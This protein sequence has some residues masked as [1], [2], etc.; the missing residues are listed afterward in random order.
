MILLWHE[1]FTK[2]FENLSD[3]SDVETRNT[4]LSASSTTN[5]QTSTTTVEKTNAHDQNRTPH[6]G[7]KNIEPT[8]RG[9]NR[10]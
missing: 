1:T 8:I 3:Y 6:N 4:T 7:S 10:G 2:F 5:Q 9:R